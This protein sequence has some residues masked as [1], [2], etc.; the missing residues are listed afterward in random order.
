MYQNKSYFHSLVNDDLAFQ[1]GPSRLG[2]VLVPSKSATLACL[3]G[4]GEALGL[5]FCDQASECRVDN[6]RLPS[7]PC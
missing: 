4:A 2:L 6:S 7:E 5:K 1:M 3:V